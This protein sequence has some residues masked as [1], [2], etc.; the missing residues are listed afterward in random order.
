MPM[1]TPATFAET[2]RPGL[3]IFIAGCAAEPTAVLDALAARPAALAAST[4]LGVPIAS[5]NR[6]D[7]SALAP[8]ECAFMTPELRAGL[9]AGRVSFRPLHYSDAFAWLRGPARADMAIF[10]CA[11]P[12]DGSVSLALTHDFVPAL[13]E[14]GAALV[15]VVDP[16]LPDVPDGVRIGLDRLH[17]LVDGP[18]ATPL[19]PVDEPGEAMAALG[20]HVAGL[21]RDGDMVQTG[22]GTA[23]AAVVQAMGGHRRLR[24]HGGM[25]GDPVL[26]LLDAGVVDAVT[27]GVA[28]GSAALHDRVAREKRIAFRPVGVT[29][30]AARIAALPSMI[31]INAAVEVD[32]FGQANSEMI[33]GRQVSAQGGV[34]D[35][36]RGA[37]RTKE[38]RAVI[39]LL[40]SGKG[41]S[42]SRIVP[43]L[44]PG[45]PVSITRGDADIVVTEHGVALLRDAD[46]DQ[47]AERL[48]AI[49]AP[50]HQVA[51][52]DGWARMRARF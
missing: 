28:I 49:A 52:A 30:D 13:M 1:I 41:G 12:R 35:F 20:R 27:T 37:R 45:T 43:Q 15:A 3:R 44:A 36:V 24:F 47:R 14:A 11:A 25:I 10:R 51:L 38:G 29:H 19:L 4:L 31:A 42:I 39:A 9:G 33:E 23:V 22:I 16:S 34:A 46:L 2:L 17:A 40:A 7:W 18:S 6:R 50:Q 8:L 5:I 21:V 26:G 48:I 32:L